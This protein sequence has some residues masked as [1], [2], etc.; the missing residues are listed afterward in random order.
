MHI[1]VDTIVDIPKTKS[2]W[3]TGSCCH[4]LEDSSHVYELSHISNVTI[5]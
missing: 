3:L 4:M 1:I 5:L 2:N